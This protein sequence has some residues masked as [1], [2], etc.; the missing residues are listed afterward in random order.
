MLIALGSKK[1]VAGVG[2]PKAGQRHA[3]MSWRALLSFQA[4]PSVKETKETR[5]RASYLTANTHTCRLSYLA[6]PPHFLPS[7]SNAN[8]A[9]ISHLLF[10]LKGK[11]A[12]GPVYASEGQETWRAAAFQ[13][14][15]HN[16]KLLEGLERDV[17]RAAQLGQA[18]L[19]RHEAYVA[20][21]ERE[22]K[23]MVTTIETL[24]KE[25][26]D[27]EAKNAQT[28]K[29]NR[30][31][32]DRLEYLNDAVLNSDA[33]IH[34]LT[35][36]LRSTEEELERLSSLA[37]QT[38][39]LEKQ[40]LDLEREQS[41]LQS[42]LDAKLVDERTAIQRWKM[43]E[44]TIGDL[45]DQID[46]I[47][48]EAREERKRHVEVV[49]RMERRMAV[50]GEL[51]TAADRLKAKAGHDKGTTNV[52]S[53]FVKDILLDNANLQHGIVELRDM[54]MTSNEEVERLRDQLTVHQPL[55][56]PPAEDTP[57]TTL[58]KEL[59]ME[60]EAISNQELHIH[61]H[62]HGPKISKNLPKPQAPRRPKKKRFSLT[63]TH[64]DPPPSLDRSSTATLLDQ[65]AATVPNSHR[66]SQASTLAPGSYPGSPVSESHRGS[67]YDRVF[68]DAAYDSSRPSSP[69]D[70]I[71]LH[72]P[73]FGPT[74]LNDYSSDQ[75]RT[76][77]HRRR[78]SHH[79]KPPS[80][81]TIRSA[82][83]PI[84]LMAKSSPA[85]AIISAVSPSNSFSNDIFTLS[86]L[87]KP[88][89]QAAIPE[90]SEDT[91]LPSPEEPE[92]DDFVSP[93]TQMRTPLRRHAS[94]ES[95]I[96]VSGMDIH[97]LQSRPS[98]LLYSSS[99]RFSTPGGA[100]SVGPELTPWTATAHGNLSKKTSDSS[101]L[102]RS[103]LYSSIA[104]QKRGPRKSDGPP[105]S[106]STGIGIGKKVGGW[107]FGKWGAAPA[108]APEPPRPTSSNSQQTQSSQGTATG[109]PDTAKKTV[110]KSKLRPS[111]VNQNGP[112]RGFFDIPETPTKV[113]VHDY[114][115]DA[116]CEALAEA[117]ST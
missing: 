109:T 100:G 113:V 31:L 86:P 59:A 87:I 44:R 47:E 116:L 20:D 101:T 103:L 73:M 3:G 54:L 4:L 34:A 53:H 76:Q 9:A 106:S 60:S 41:Q 61:H 108:P 38:Q 58:Q 92:P 75:D 40:L 104:N 67:I 12:N 14:P 30:D 115:A 35:D 62:Y 25:K 93:L 11:T 26:L 85:T 83:T 90:E 72:S 74:R 51:N 43:A 69:P 66:M 84:S 1:T 97:T 21:S 91:P 64:F 37:A 52:V 23:Q 13:A 55:S 70:S 22:R 5:A 99:P 71:D 105:T 45:Q 18:L 56:T 7:M 29:A 8:Y 36:T 89:P 46:R 10:P 63:P 42:N 114:D 17:S 65:T 98:Q 77:K 95:L 19:V 57:A 68:S 111:G 107:V 79:L 117:S 94:H 28:I 81:S 82:S 32:L 16:G 110:D 96:S 15:A 112:I 39:M 33:H 6:N 49:A 27:L 80:L 78:R 50:E 48:K 2:K 102:N 88:E 24:E